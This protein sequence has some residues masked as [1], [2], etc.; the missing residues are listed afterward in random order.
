[1]ED[2]MHLTTAEPAAPVSTADKTE[3]I[4]T[5]AQS[6]DKMRESER[7][8]QGSGAPGRLSGW[9]SF[10]PGA[11]PLDGRS[12]RMQLPA[13]P[14]EPVE[15]SADSSVRRVSIAF[16]PIGIAVA[17]VWLALDVPLSAHDPPD[18]RA[19]RLAVD[20][21]I[22][23]LFGLD[24]GREVYLF[25]QKKK[26]EE[27]FGAGSLLSGAHGANSLPLTLLCCDAVAVLPV[28]VLWPIRSSEPQLYEFLRLC[29]LFKLVRVYHRAYRSSTAVF[30]LTVTLALVWTL[31]VFTIITQE[32]SPLDSSELP[33]ESSFYWVVYTLTSVGY[34]DTS[35]GDTVS[36]KYYASFLMVIGLVG[37][38]LFIGKVAEVLARQDRTSRDIDQGVQELH[39]L[40]EYYRVPK[41]LSQEA[42]KWHAHQLSTHAF[43][44]HSSAIET[45][46]DTMREKVCLCARR[47]I[48]EAVPVLA[49]LSDDC[50][51]DMSTGL[52]RVVLDPGDILCA[53]GEP[54]EELFFITH[55]VCQVFLGKKGKSAV[56]LKQGD[57]CGERGVLFG[58]SYGAL[59]RAAGY[60]DCLSV[61]RHLALVC[62]VRHPMF[63]ERLRRVISRRTGS[64]VLPDN[65]VSR[66]RAHPR[67][68][69]LLQC[70]ILQAQLL[71]LEVL[72]EA[73]ALESHRGEPTPTQ[74][75]EDE[76][77]FLGVSSPLMAPQL[78]FNDGT[79]NL[80]GVMRVDLKS[81]RQAA[82]GLD[83]TSSGRRDTEKELSAIV[84]PQN[85]AAPVTLP[86]TTSLHQ[87]MLAVSLSERPPG[88]A[89]AMTTA[90]SSQNP[91]L[92][93]SGP[94]PP[95]KS[96]GIERA[97]TF[98]NR[99]SSDAGQPGG[100]HT[101]LGR[102]TSPMIT[103]QP[104]NTA[105]TSKHLSGLS[106]LPVMKRKSDVPLQS[107]AP[108]EDDGLF[109][110]GR[111]PAAVQFVLEDEQQQEDFAG[112]ASLATSRTSV[113]GLGPSRRSVA[114]PGLSAGGVRVVQSTPEDESEDEG[115]AEPSGHTPRRRKKVGIDRELAELRHRES[116]IM[117]MLEA[118]QETQDR[119]L[120]VVTDD[121][122][123]APIPSL[124]SMR[125]IADAV[126]SSG[127]QSDQGKQPE[128]APQPQIGGGS[129]K[130]TMSG[131]SLFSM[132]RK[133]MKKNA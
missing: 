118:V 124:G 49:G 53:Q 108:P 105:T 122:D 87:P 97:T 1:M 42:L 94:P 102:N 83:T 24:F 126:G 111:Q 64:A 54:A 65:I 35:I 103:L 9:P 81:R 23:A 95:L 110:L 11:N 62:C 113:I 98:R 59:V 8:A 10:D 37:S 96:P 13:T 33:Y 44:H 30:G 40:M 72:E 2:E 133:R 7:S 93:L 130:A 45:L 18:N 39:S 55:G 58:E 12:L 128:A 107:K 92:S 70:P 14:L 121:A 66:I 34:G 38:G 76:F 32:V 25:R 6:S 75:D 5:V 68:D 115:D 119:I 82:A 85:E 27:F 131:M 77:H 91:E 43:E 19:E 79:T 120:R 80:Q 112:H 61:P 15:T 21:F 63:E 74:D 22:L 78:R 36:V 106:K 16:L 89:G 60:V 127:D 50:L 67:C 51:E 3:S 73:L 114:F 99:L 129:L 116:K 88:T 47:R 28:E 4:A 41:D 57:I 46:P 101:P 125:Q 109:S 17:A 123:P 90:L 117:Q 52:S 20:L 69:E 84:S 29:R 132:Q 56:T 86:H 104:F 31:H 100:K 48:L 26:E 71:T